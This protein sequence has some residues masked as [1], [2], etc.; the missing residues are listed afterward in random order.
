MEATTKIITPTRSSDEIT[1]EAWLDTLP[2]TLRSAVLA[3]VFR[4]E[5]ADQQ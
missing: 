4:T 3:E 5:D 2:M 1:P